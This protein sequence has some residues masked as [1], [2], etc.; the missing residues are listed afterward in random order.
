M[1]DWDADMAT[2]TNS[3]ARDMPGCSPATCSS[4]SSQHKV[5]LHQLV[6]CQIGS[7][8]SPTPLNRPAPTTA[9]MSST[10]DDSTTPSMVTLDVHPLISRR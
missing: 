8:S 4:A 7:V 1:T 10:S 2:S 6:M 5:A 3:P 9:P